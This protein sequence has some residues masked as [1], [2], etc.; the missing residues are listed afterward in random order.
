[1]SSPVSFT[2]TATPGKRSPT[3]AWKSGRSSARNLGMLLSCMARIS[4]TSSLKFGKARLSEPA[5]TSTDLTARMP[6]S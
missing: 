6:K 1:M 3:M 5:M 2:G 4:T